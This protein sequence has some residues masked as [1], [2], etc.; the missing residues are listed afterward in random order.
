MINFCLHT[1]I[2]NSHYD[3][4]SKYDSGGVPLTVHIVQIA[5]VATVALAYHLAMWLLLDIAREKRLLRIVYHLGCQVSVVRLCNLTLIAHA[6]SAQ[7]VLIQALVNS[8]VAMLFVLTRSAR[9]L[10]QYLLLKIILC[11]GGAHRENCTSMVGV[12]GSWRGC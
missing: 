4:L 6:S 3:N 12:V 8:R 7:L 2:F 5:S 11:D 10:H 9:A 1:P